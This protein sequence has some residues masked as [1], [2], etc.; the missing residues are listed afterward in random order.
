LIPLSRDPAVLAY[1]LGELTVSAY[2]TMLRRQLLHRQTSLG[3]DQVS[4]NARRKLKA[5]KSQA[6]LEAYG[7]WGTWHYLSLER[8]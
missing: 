2:P 4:G 6:E 1:H 7:N 5:R 8:H 3:K